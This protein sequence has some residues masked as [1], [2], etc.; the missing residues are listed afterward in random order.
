MSNQKIT[1]IV[2]IVLTI[3]LAS[4]V[5]IGVW[6]ADAAPEPIP[7][8][9]A[10]TPEPAEPTSAPEPTE[11]PAPDIPDEEKTY[12]DRLIF[13]GD[14]TTY[15]LKYYG[16]LS[17]GRAT[18]QVWTPSSGTLALFNQSFATIVY[19]ETGAEIP[20][21]D[22]VADA[23]PEYIVLT[24]GV[25]GVSMMKEESFKADYTDLVKRI[26]SVSPDTK[27]IC[28]SIY[29]VESKYEKAGHGITNAKINAANGWIKNI[30]A[31]TGTFFT[32]SA[33]VLKGDDGCLVPEYGN[34]DGLHLSP[35]GFEL[36]LD[37]LR[38]H[39]V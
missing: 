7:D 10:Q 13:I 33:S 5:I 26:Q 32:D 9:I 8:D 37:Y 19:P 24:I 36:V 18:T 23:Q 30:A 38:E 25:N 28:N 29:P 3:L 4:A 21:T 35:K 20:I 17:G 6:R 27:I 22:A 39:E 34:G 16:V 15:G 2:F 14:S 31:D 11:T 12:I 1:A